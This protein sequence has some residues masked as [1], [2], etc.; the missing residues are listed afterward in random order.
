MRRRNGDDFGSHAIQPDT[1]P[2]TAMRN[3]RE[4]VHEKRQNVDTGS[5]ARQQL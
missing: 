2:A 1:V 5:D 3:K 4:R